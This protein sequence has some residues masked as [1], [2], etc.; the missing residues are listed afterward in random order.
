MVFAR[1]TL[2]EQALAIGQS[3]Q[4]SELQK[5]PNPYALDLLHAS[6]SLSDASW[7]R[8]VPLQFGLQ[9][10][11]YA[12]RLRRGLEYNAKLRCMVGVR[13]AAHVPQPRPFLF[14]NL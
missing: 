3:Q 7:P 12:H 1:V 13:L 14:L 8:R 5:H 6:A 2:K 11:A 4:A 9:A 10:R